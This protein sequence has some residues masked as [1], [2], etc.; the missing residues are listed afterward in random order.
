[1]TTP[2]EIAGAGP[3]GLAAALTVVKEGN[4]AIVSER[5]GDVGHRFNGD[6][7]GLENWTTDGDVIDEL[8]AIG[9]DPT[10][11]HTPFKECVYFDPSGREYVYRSER[12]IWYLV[13]RGS[14]AG[15]LD[16]GLKTQALEA[17]AEIRFNTAQEHLPEGGIVAHGPRRADAIAVGYV[18][19]SDRA[20]GA[21]A[22]ISDELAPKGY[23]YLLICGGRATIAS[24]MFADFH[25]EKIYLDRTVEFFREKVGLEMTNARRFGGFGNVIVAHDPRKGNMLYVGEAAGFQDALFGFGMRYAMLSGHL[26]A[27]AWL[28]ERPE[29]YDRLWRER[30]GGLLRAAVVN[31]HFYEKIGNRGY[32]SL[33]SRIE[34]ASD[35]RNWLRRYYEGGWGKSLLYPLARRGLKRK[36]D[37]VAGCI[38]GCDCTW[39]RCEH[40][41]A[42]RY[43]S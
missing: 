8:E 26:A 34:G 1:M 15:T 18:F 32:A 14:T 10:F 24:C 35:V 28:Q 39:C 27:R 40:A 38:E 2:I 37:L 5:H 31:R 4:H 7:Q 17:G 25:Q 6:F 21:F 30:L 3:A 13:R 29:I 19:E 36:S 11:E 9:I 22:A 12:P 43:S 42:T 23:S 33:M 20:D 41:G 16:H